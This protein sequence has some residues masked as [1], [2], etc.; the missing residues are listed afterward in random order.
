MLYD[1]ERE[2]EIELMRFAINPRKGLAYG[3]DGQAKM[4][5]SPLSDPSPLL[6]YRFLQSWFVRVQHARQSLLRNDIL[7]FACSGL[8]LNKLSDREA[9]HYYCSRPCEN[10]SL[11]LTLAIADYIHS[12]YLL[13]LTHL[14]TAGHSISGWR[15][16]KR[17]LPNLG[18][19]YSRSAKSLQC[20]KNLFYYFM[21]Q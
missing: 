10:H 5:V 2:K 18:I 12:Y 8:K 7:L 4:K 11:S 6:R 16:E 9:D 3:K 20:N 14:I 15:R 19:V 1:V 13:L 17:G 21:Q